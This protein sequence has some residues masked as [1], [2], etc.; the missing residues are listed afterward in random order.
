MR[1]LCRMGQRHADHESGKLK[2]GIGMKVLFLSSNKEKREEVLRILTSPLITVEPVNEKIAE[3]QDKDMV[4]IAEDKAI[5]GFKKVWRPVLVEQTGVLLKGFGDLPG[6]F[7]QIFWDS[8]EA[9]QFSRFFSAPD[10]GIAVARSVFAYCDGRQIKIF[11]E[12]TPGRIVDTPRGDTSS[13]WDCVFQ[14]DGY[15]QTF[16]EMRGEKDRC[17]MRRLALKA[18]RQYLEAAG[19]A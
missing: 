11:E 15:T 6:G 17:S 3:M 16:A 5:R 10:S 9:E 1:V 12:E 2:G 18:V 19:H 8:L 13:G 4:K 7:T 14:P